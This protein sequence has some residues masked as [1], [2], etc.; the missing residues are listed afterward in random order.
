MKKIENEEFDEMYDDIDR[1]II[2]VCHKQTKMNMGFLIQIDQ[3]NIG[4]MILDMIWLGTK[5]YY[6]GAC[7]TL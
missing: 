1:E 2:E 3:K 6:R 4:N 7:F 5:I